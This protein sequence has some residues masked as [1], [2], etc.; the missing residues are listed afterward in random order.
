MQDRSYNGFGLNPLK[1]YQ[2]F[3]AKKVVRGYFEDFI[4]YSKN[5]HPLLMLCFAH[6]MHPYGSRRNR[7]MAYIGAFL[8]SFFGGGLMLLIS[9]YVDLD[10]GLEIILGIMFVTIPLVLFQKLVFYLFVAPW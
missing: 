4:F 9:S 6:K 3:V 7:Y 5:S 2:K 10:P 8:T 1:P